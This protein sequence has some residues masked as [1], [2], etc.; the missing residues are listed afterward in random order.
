MA[1]VVCY[2]TFDVS[3]HQ[4]HTASSLRPYYRHTS[5]H[6]T[7]TGQFN[8]GFVSGVVL[9]GGVVGVVLP[10]ASLSSSSSSSSSSNTDVDV[11]ASSSPSYS[12]ATSSPSLTSSPSSP[13]P[14]PLSSQS[15]VVIRAKVLANEQTHVD[16][17]KV[18]LT[19]H[20]LYVKQR[21]WHS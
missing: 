13:P 10:S 7:C 6:Y 2:M 12:A 8:D 1:I 9:C 5:K 17:I 19:C 16:E 18:C 15:T 3:W 21:M 20:M 11:I 14:H 4:H